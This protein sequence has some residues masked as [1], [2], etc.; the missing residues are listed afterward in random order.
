MTIKAPGC[1]CREHLDYLNSLLTF[2]QILFILD[3]WR[4][5]L[6][7]AF[8][9]SASEDLFNKSNLNIDKELDGFYE[10]TLFDD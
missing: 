9:A 1:F 5:R 10:P 2:D 8:L 6:S 3:G 4:C 7:T